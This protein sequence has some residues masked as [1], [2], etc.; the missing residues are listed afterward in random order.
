MST[1]SGAT[2]FD[3]RLEY[4]EFAKEWDGLT[5]DGS[6]D[7]LDSITRYY[8][9]GGLLAPAAIGRGGDPE[10]E[11]RASS[12]RLPVRS[13]RLR[14]HAADSKSQTLSIRDAS[15]KSLAVSPPASWL[16]RSTTTR[17]QPT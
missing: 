11:E 6:L 2:K 16:E 7:A 12:R 13:A 3:Q 10:A 17:P 15:L 9:E 14:R 4:V 1:P 8:R 5:V